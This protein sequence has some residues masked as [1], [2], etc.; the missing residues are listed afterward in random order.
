[1]SRADVIRL[2]TQEAAFRARVDA[3]ICNS[4]EAARRLIQF[5][6]RCITQTPL[7]NGM[8]PL[9]LLD[10]QPAIQ[11]GVRLVA[12]WLSGE[13]VS[14]EQLQD[15]W[16]TARREAD[17][18]AKDMVGSTAAQWAAIETIEATQAA[19]AAGTR[20]SQKV[21]QAV[22]FAALYS[23]AAGIRPSSETLQ[24][25]VDLADELLTAD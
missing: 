6:Y 19:A 17:T 1:M 2:A 3:L 22:A 9:T 13:S 11:D 4:P 25:Q 15:A 5:A 18:L 23:R 7:D 14:E 10:A 20:A 21:P 16:M 8:T 24:F 12:R